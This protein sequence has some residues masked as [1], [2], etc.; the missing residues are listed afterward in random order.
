ME[1]APAGDAACMGGALL[2]HRLAQEG[3][4][5]RIL[6]FVQPG[7]LGDM[8]AFAESAFVGASDPVT[9]DDGLD[10]YILRGKAF[11]L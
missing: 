1:F 5:G 6:A 11:S 4:Q 7:P 2:G 10:C 9:G 3:V 8:K